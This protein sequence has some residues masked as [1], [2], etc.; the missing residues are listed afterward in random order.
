MD[1]SVFH[2]PEDACH[3]GR[4]ND[5]DEDGVEETEPLHVVL[6][7]GAQDVVPTRRPAHVIIYLMEETESLIDTGKT[8]S[9]S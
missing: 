1:D 8:S 6:R 7:G 2:K 9:S 3:H 5:C 4:Y